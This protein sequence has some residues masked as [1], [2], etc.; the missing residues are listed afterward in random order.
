V[1]GALW[2]VRNPASVHTA[3]DVAVGELV[4]MNTFELADSLVA[5]IIVAEVLVIGLT[6]IPEI[7]GAVTSATLPVTNEPCADV[8]VLFDASVLVMMK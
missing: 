7:I 4:E 8:P 6:V 1:S 2:L 5:H 3:L